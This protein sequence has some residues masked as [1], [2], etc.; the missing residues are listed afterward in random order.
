V[1]FWDPL[2]DRRAFIRHQGRFPRF[3]SS[4]VGEPLSKSILNLS[5]AYNHRLLGPTKTDAN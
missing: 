2:F 3:T 1:W 5:V 4:H